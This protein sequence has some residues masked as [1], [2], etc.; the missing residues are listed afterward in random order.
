MP[1]KEIIARIPSNPWGPVAEILAISTELVGN[2]ELPNYSLTFETDGFTISPYL[3]LSLDRDNQ[4]LMEIT[5]NNFL[6]PK[7]KPEKF[8]LLESFGWLPPSGNN[9][10]Y[11]RV[12]E[13]GYSP[14]AI[15]TYSLTVFRMTFDVNGKGTMRFSSASLNSLVSLGKSFESTPDGGFRLSKAN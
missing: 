13:R 7:V 10:N 12:F 14:L 3:Q 11:S 15:A 4:Y 5:S 2:L 1:S 6:E 9:P 8:S